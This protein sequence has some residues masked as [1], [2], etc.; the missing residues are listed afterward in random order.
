ML[1]N[2]I[3]FRDQKI[4]EEPL[5]KGEILLPGYR[6]MQHMRR[7]GDTD[8]YHVWSEE[9]L[10]GCIAKTLQPEKREDEIARK[11][12]IREGTYLKQLS[13]PNLVRGYEI[14]RDPTPILIQ[15]TLTGETLSHLI[16]NLAKEGNFL[17]LKQLAHLGMQLASVVHYL[18]QYNILHL[19]LKPSNIISQP[20]LAKVIDLNLAGPPGEERKGVGTRQYM[21]PEQ[22][23]GDELTR[24][25]DIW[26]LGAVFFFAITGKRP[27]R[28]MDD[29]NYEQ[30]ERPAESVLSYREIDP[31]F[32][33]LIASCLQEVPEKRPTTTEIH[34][35]FQNL[36]E[37][38]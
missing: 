25:A 8:V 1:T 34:M 37:N 11:R 31:S 13:H 19:D 27:F 24:A 36:I 20:P 6:V 32:A 30:L 38:N 7:G 16:R 17:P 2:N 23:R 18:H 35:F 12:I 4:V 28:S 29:G 26:G 21:A 5:Q 22:A 10:T 33:E 15:E 3:D 9:R 14:V